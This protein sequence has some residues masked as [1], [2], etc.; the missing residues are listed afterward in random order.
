MDRDLWA[1]VELRHLQ[2]LRA[3]AQTGSFQGAADALDYAQPAI[4]QQLAALEEIVG[5]RLVDRRRGSRRATLT[6]AGQ[7][8]VGHAD[9][10][11]TRLRVARAELSALAEG[12]AGTIRVGTYQSVSARILPELLRRFFDR[13][14]QV[15][16][17]LQEGADES[18]LPAR[19]AVGEI[20]LAFGGLPALDQPFDGVELLRDPWFLLTSKGSPLADRRGPLSVDAVDGERLI[21]FRIT[22]NV[23]AGLEAFL[24]ASGVNPRIIFRTDDNATV[25][26][27]VAT[28]FGSAL[29]PA[30]V[31][32]S[33]DP[34]LVRIP[35]AIPP[36]VIAITWHRDRAQSPAAQAFVATAREV[37]TELV[38][39]T[40]PRMATTQPP[41]GGR[42]AR[43]RDAGAPA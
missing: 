4:S 34:R 9:A 10:V 42:A 30:L 33:T 18:E 43:R 26:G 3:I 25:Q 24:N 16:V 39:P 21:A 6:E 35:I 2:T 7:L 15:N 14:P 8:L 1:G 40:G 11:A 19:L 17:E 12:T 28:G 31:I 32:D 38:L 20:D 41:T 29:L 27:L 23:Q 5:L 22:G 13:W 37:C 36:R